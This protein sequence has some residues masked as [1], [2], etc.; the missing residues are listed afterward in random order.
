MQLNKKLIILC[1]FITLISVCGVYAA[2]SY[3]NTENLQ[4]IIDE[5]NIT[6]D[7]GCCSIVL[8]LDGNNSIF[9]YRRDA[10]TS[11]EI[12]IDK[13]DWHGMPAI[14][15]HKDD[16]GYFTHVV[17]TEDGWIIGLGGVDDGEDNEKC[18]EIASKMINKENKISEDYLN[19]IQ[20]IK[21]PYKKGHFIIK[22]PNG[23]YGFATVDKVKTGK[24][25]PGSYISLP[26]SYKYSRA[27]NFTMNT[28][29]K[30]AEMNEL[31]QT[32]LFGLSRRDVVTYVFN[33]T[34]KANTT[35]IYVS[36][37][38]GSMVGMNNINDVDDVYVG[39][40]LTKAD[41]IP[42]APN[43]KKIG[44]MTFENSNQTSSNSASLLIIFIIFVVFVG[45]LFMAVLK[46]VKYLR[47]K[48]KRR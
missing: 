33:V 10:N 41:Q 17:I 47:I 23:N 36:N 15:Q 22:A 29:D 32:D 48:I 37:D 5:S 7:S 18:E 19:Q 8:Q 1:I 44:N 30:I 21:T 28:S 38:D 3:Q 24:L 34:D 11:S 12:H 25:Q 42:T 9:T 16:G 6:N 43:Y 26:N 40:N 20:Q 35:D 45:I 39:N 14:R 2:Y 4:T 27:D 31:A 13:I 46:L